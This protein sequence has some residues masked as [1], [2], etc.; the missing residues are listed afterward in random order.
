MKTHSAIG[1]SILSDEGDYLKELIQGNGVTLPVHHTNDI[2]RKTASIIAE[3]HHE[4]WDGSGYPNGLVGDEIPIIGQITALADVYDAL[5]SERPYKKPFDIDKTI[6]IIKEGSGTHFNPKLV[7][8]LLAHIDT[9][10]LIRTKYGCN[11]NLENRG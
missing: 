11:V 9:I 8:L 3:T 6:M 7:N 4:K 5:R 2:L 10:E 1:A